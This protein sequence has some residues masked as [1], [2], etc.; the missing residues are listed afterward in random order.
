MHAHHLIC[1]EHLTC[2]AHAYRVLYHR[3]FHLSHIIRRYITIRL[4]M[5]TTASPCF[6]PGPSHPH[7]DRRL[8]CLQCPNSPPKLPKAFNA[9]ILMR[10]VK[11]GET[12]LT[13]SCETCEIWDSLINH[14]PSQRSSQIGAI[15]RQFAMNTE[16]KVLIEF[17]WIPPIANV[18]TFNNYFR[19]KVWKPN[20]QVVCT[21]C[22]LKRRSLGP[23]ACTGEKSDM[24]SAPQLW[25][26]M[27]M[28]ECSGPTRNKVLI[29]SSRDSK[30]LASKS[31]K[32]TCYRIL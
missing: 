8:E 24:P 11:H 32:K 2:N 21:V 28:R 19:S 20:G 22:T 18:S 25:K 7:P 17:W 14:V 31:F 26:N 3:S 29:P 6:S 10:R 16:G 9:Q 23:T 15:V 30:F 27:L 5:A 12:I 13:S 4:S 1:S